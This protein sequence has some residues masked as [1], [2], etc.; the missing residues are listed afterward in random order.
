[1]RYFLDIA[2]NGTNY[3]G[4][5]V[6]QNAHTVQGEL[7]AALSKL[8]RQPL[9]VIGSGRTDTGVHAEQ[10]LVHLDWEGALDLDQLQ[11]RLN[12]MMPPDIAVKNIFPVHPKAH[13]RFSATAR[14]YEYRISRRKNPFLQ[15]LCYVNPRPLD[16]GAMNSAA[17]M[18]LDWEDFECF[19]K[20]HTEVKHFRCTIQEARWAEEGE[21]LTFY[22]TANRFLRNMVRAIVGTLLE[23]G[24]QRMSLSGFREVLESH[25]RS[26]AG[27]SAPAQGLFLTR[28]EYP[29]KI[30][31][32]PEQNCGDA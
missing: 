19:S 4:W 2:Y 30:Y 28:V 1:L 12:A 25:D 3:H 31:T 17:A 22:I 15:K 7:E 10:Q 32:I 24:Q 14:S 23:V 9:G 29:E 20:V 16:V 8:L 6:Q 11:F 26:R 5:Q 21:R 13:A 18:M 27:R